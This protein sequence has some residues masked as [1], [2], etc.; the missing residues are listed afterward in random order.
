M[1]ASHSNGSSRKQHVPVK[2]A[3]HVYKS[4]RANGKWVYE[5]RYPANAE[6]KRPFVTVGPRLDEAK[7]QAHKVHSPDADRIVNVHTKLNEVAESWRKSRNYKTRSAQSFDDIYRLRI[8]RTLGDKKVRD[9]DKVVILHWLNGLKRLDGKDGELSSGTKALALATLNLV[10]G[11]AVNI[12][13]LG[14]VPKLDRNVKPKK[15]ENRKRFLTRDEAMRLVAF[16][17]NR[18]WLQDII[19]VALNQGLR[20]G[21]VLGLQWDDV[22]FANGKL[23]VRHNLGRD[24][25]LGTPKG[26]KAAS[27]DLMPA[28]RAVLHELRLDNPNGSGFVFVNTLGEPRHHKDVQRGFNVARAK[29]GLPVTF[30]GTVTF[31]S[32]RHTAIT[33]L[34]NHPGVDIAY[35]RDFA[36]HSSL[37][38]TNGYVHAVENAATTAN[39]AAALAGVTA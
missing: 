20:L 24:R 15:A 38:I 27:I 6:G 9:I 4:E 26:G 32:L 30:D 14:A 16:C 2:H 10:L 5:V 3:A 23:H 29:A 34:A 13:V 28:A 17:G 35:V 12:G 8:E 21:E 36:R 31:H 37:A 25:K 39:A 7:A 19:A 11:H 1:S 18:P 33:W 22:D